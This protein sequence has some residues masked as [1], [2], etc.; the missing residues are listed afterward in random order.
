KLDGKNAHTIT[1]SSGVN[2][3]TM[4]LSA[5]VNNPK[6]AGSNFFLGNAFGFGLLDANGRP[7]LDLRHRRSTG[8]QAFDNAVRDNLP[9]V[10]Y[11]YWTGYVTHKPFSS[12]KS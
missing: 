1:V 6:T 9:T 12:E 10:V 11:M 8:L 4:L 7:S 5:T 2:V 3:S